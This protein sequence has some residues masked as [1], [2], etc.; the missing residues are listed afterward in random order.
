MFPQAH[1]VVGYLKTNKIHTY[2]L[3]PVTL[4][5]IAAVGIPFATIYCSNGKSEMG[6]N[7]LPDPFKVNKQT[8]V[9]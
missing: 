2:F 4:V 3:H 6:E 9:T 8:P 7:K 5:S 1:W